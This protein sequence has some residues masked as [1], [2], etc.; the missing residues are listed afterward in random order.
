MSL[1]EVIKKNITENSKAIGFDEFM[2]LALY[3]NQYGY[4]RTNKQK[5]GK[6]G[7]FT[8]SCELSP[9]FA[10]CLAKQIIEVIDNKYNILEFGAGS[11]IL[12]VNI[13]QY[14][15]KQ[16]KLPKNYY[17]LELSASL[18]QQQQQTIN[19]HIPELANKCVWIT[20]LLNNFNGVVIANEVLDAMPSKRF[21]FK[22]GKSFELCVSYKNEDFIWKKQE[23]N[24]NF[25]FITTN[26]LKNITYKTEVNYYIKP[27][28]ELLYNSLNKATIFIIDYGYNNSEYYHPQRKDGTLRCYYKHQISKDVFK[29]IGEQD[30]T[31]SVNFSWVYNYAKD[32]GFN[33]LGYSTQ[34]HFLLNL[35]LVNMITD[36][37]LSKYEQIKL[38]TSV[39]QLVLPSAMGE[40][41]KVIALGK[42]TKI[43]CS[44]FNLYDMSHKLI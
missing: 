31:T 32:I 24:K 34:A 18:Q 39:K 17:I 12:A 29:N 26:I 28:L 25:N 20:N 2:N 37:D 21:L 5:F 11:G 22:D 9:L 40:I 8:T 42:N 7:D 27:W 16:N 41:F 6:H 35:G 33:I 3:H 14:L 23:T 10:N 13:L 43:K 15:Q 1:K 36:N 44:G 30:I 38:A 4:Y 19:K